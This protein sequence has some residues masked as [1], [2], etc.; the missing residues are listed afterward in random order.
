MKDMSPYIRYSHIDPLSLDFITLCESESMIQVRYLL[1][2]YRSRMCYSS[3]HDDGDGG[4]IESQ[5]KREWR[6]KPLEALPE[7]MHSKRDQSEVNHLK[8]DRYTASDSLSFQGSHTVITMKSATPPASLDFDTAIVDLP[9]TL[10]VGVICY[11]PIRDEEHC[12]T[13]LLLIQFICF[14]SPSSTLGDFA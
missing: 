10:T 1:D 7:I 8:F 12:W 13:F 9:L 14:I 2:A 5:E 3:R 6:K 11:C 4:G